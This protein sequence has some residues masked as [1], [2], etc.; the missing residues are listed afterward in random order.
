MDMFRIEKLGLG[1]QEHR[2]AG[3]AVEGLGTQADR[4]QMGQEGND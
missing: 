1:G 4:Q 3:Q 2:K